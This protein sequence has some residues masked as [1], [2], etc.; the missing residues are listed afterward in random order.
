VIEKR[1]GRDVGYRVITGGLGPDH[2][3]I[4]RFRAKHEQ[5][6]GGLFSEV[7][8]LLAA[9][10]MVSPGL[11]SLDG[12]ELAGTAAQKADRTLPQI[13][14][15]LAEAAVADAAEDARYG[16]A[17]GEPAPRTLARRAERRGRLAA[18]RNRLAAGDKERRDA[19]RAKQQAWDAAAAAGKP[20]G[21]RPGDEPRANRA[22]TE[23]GVRVMRNHKGYLAGYNGQAV[24]TAQQV[25]AGAMVSE[26]PAGRTLLHPLPDQCRSNR[27]RR[28]SGRSRAP[29]SPMP[30]TPARTTSSA[31]TRTNC[32]CSRRWPKTPADRAG[33]L[34]KGP[35]TW[36][37]IRPLSALSGACGI[38]ADGRTARCGPAPP[39]RCPAS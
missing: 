18:A 14:K 10:G 15:L 8:R 20:R 6:T 16:D 33:A 31:L 5:A 19:Q 4:A 7:L 12:T 36:R 9:G 29:C 38:P 2:A 1:C 24:V 37:S 35:G 3:A 11:L 28:G 34:P 21:R 30:G 25:I 13:E 17:A 23:P 39:N 26:H 27:T 22:G 32:G